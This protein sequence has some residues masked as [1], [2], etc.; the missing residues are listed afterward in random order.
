MNG[1]VYHESVI[2]AAVGGSW[3]DENGLTPSDIVILPTGSTVDMR[4]VPG[5]AAGATSGSQAYGSC[6]TYRF[7]LAS[8]RAWTTIGELHTPADTEVATFTYGRKAD[9]YIAKAFSLDGSFWVM[10]GTV[11]V[12]NETGSTSSATIAYSTKRDRWAHEIQTEFVY[13]KYR[14]ELWCASPAAV[15]VSEAYEIRAT[16]WVGSSRLGTGPD[17]PRRPVRRGSRAVP[18]AVSAR[19]SGSRATRTDTAPSPTPLRSP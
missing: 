1:W 4:L 12:A 11:R 7:P 6:V 3:V 5:A 9:S 16:K 19:T 18:R 13:T 17:A 15:K 14:T 8:A 10:K 2:R